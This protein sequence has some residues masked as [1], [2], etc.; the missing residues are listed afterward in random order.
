MRRALLPLLL[1]AVVGCAS[2]RE[3]TPRTHLEDA[4]AVYVACVETATTLLQAKVMDVKTANAFESVRKRVADLIAAAD[5]AI[6]AGA[7][8]D[9]SDLDSSLVSAQNIIQIVQASG[10]THGH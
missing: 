9:F 3:A 6:A 8:F 5:S 7:S 10:V 4:R 2:F 1:V